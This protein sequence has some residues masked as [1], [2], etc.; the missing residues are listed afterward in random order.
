MENTLTH[1]DVDLMEFSNIIL[2]VIVRRGLITI[3]SY[4]VLLS[5]NSVDII[6]FTIAYLEVMVL[7]CVK[8]WLVLLVTLDLMMYLSMFSYVDNNNTILKQICVVLT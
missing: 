6:V 1:L 8:L 5:V 2:T 4:R 7:I 3:D